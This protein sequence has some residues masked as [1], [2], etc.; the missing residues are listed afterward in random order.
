MQKKKK[1][2]LDRI[3]EPL[4]VLQD[5]KP[6]ESQLMLSG[7]GVPLIRYGSSVKGQM[8]LLSAKEGTWREIKWQPSMKGQ[9][10]TDL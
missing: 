1:N 7:P 6:E 3:G 4:C 9:V 8:T 2:A 5:G 10:E